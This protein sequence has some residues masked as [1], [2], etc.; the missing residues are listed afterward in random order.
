MHAQNQPTTYTKPTKRKFQVRLFNLRRVAK[1]RDLNPED[2]DHLV[3]LR[4]MV[5]RLFMFI[6]YVKYMCIYKLLVGCET[7]RL[8]CMCAEV[9][10]GGVSTPRMWTIWWRSGEWCVVCWY[11]CTIYIRVAMYVCTYVC[12]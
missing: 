7:V 8:L 9:R 1:M 4:G 11:A 6:K 5:R 10:V 2:V 3:A 12:D